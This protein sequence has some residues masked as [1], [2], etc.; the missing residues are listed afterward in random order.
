MPDPSKPKLP[1]W[2][3]DS[4]PKTEKP[5]PEPEVITPTRVIPAGEQVP[6]KPDYPP[7][8]A[9]DHQRADRLTEP[10]HDP[11]PTWF[12]AL[13][14]KAL[15]HDITT[16]PAARQGATPDVEDVEPWYLR[17]PGPSTPGAGEGDDGSG[18]VMPEVS[19]KVTVTT[20]IPQKPST[21]PARSNP[22]PGGGGGSSQ[23]PTGTGGG[24]GGAEPP[25]DGGD[26]EGCG[27]CT[28]RCNAVCNYPAGGG[29]PPADPEPAEPVEQEV[30]VEV[31]VKA[32]D[33]KQPRKKGRLP[34]VLQGTPPGTGSGWH[35]PRVRWA[36]KW[37]APGIVGWGF[38]CLDKAEHLIVWF[39]DPGTQFWMGAVFV[40]AGGWIAWK[41]RG[42]WPPLAWLLRVPMATTILA[43]LLTPLSH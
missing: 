28:F 1:A 18:P 4:T 16:L 42:W 14:D 23:P 7:L 31:E 29:E 32:S 10:P 22:Q 9:Q 8:T 19:A 13:R 12:T 36:F 3:W 2:L 21:S 35:G 37:I 11:A 30:K 27:G 40:A 20:K 33:P 15:A 41:T 43:V 17:R 5:E 34:E 6:P 25:A 38:D 39:H 26:G 24:C